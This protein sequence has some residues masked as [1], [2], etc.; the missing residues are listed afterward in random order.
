[1]FQGPIEWKPEA[2]SYSGRI[3]HDLRR[4]AVRDLI[5]SSVSQSVAMSISGHKTNSMFTRYNITDDKDQRKAL[6]M[7]QQYLKTAKQ[8]VVTGI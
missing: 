8:N 5:H 7:R 3:I 4:S 1:V 6:L 2:L